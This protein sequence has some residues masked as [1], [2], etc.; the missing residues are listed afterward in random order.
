[1]GFE[2]RALDEG[3]KLD[4]SKKNSEIA[5]K[6]IESYW[7]KEF[8]RIQQIDEAYEK[9]MR[10]ISQLYHRYSLFFLS[11]FYFSS[12]SE[13]SSAGY[14]STMDF[15]RYSRDLKQ[16]YV[17]YYLDKKF[18]TNEEK[19]ENFINGDENVYRSSGKLSPYFGW[20]LAWTYL[21]TLLLFVWGYFRFKKA[22]YSLE[23]ERKKR[24]KRKKRSKPGKPGAVKEVKPPEIPELNLTAGQYR[25]LESMRSNQSFP[26]M[27][28][29]LFSGRI[30]EAVKSRYNGKIRFEGKDITTTPI[31]L[32][33][34]QSFVYLCH[35]ENIPGEIITGNLV[36]L[37]NDFLKANQK[38][39]AKEAKTGTLIEK[40][41][42]SDL[43]DIDN[44]LAKKFGDL[45]DIERFEILVTFAELYNAQIYLFEHILHDMPVKAYLR[46]KQVM[47]NLSEEGS[48][49]INIVGDVLVIPSG[50]PKTSEYTDHKRWS[51]IVDGYRDI[52]TTG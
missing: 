4:L 26:A 30:S 28:Y 51:K 35:P 16:E 49:V 18:Y 20:G 40:L 42:E 50:E 7:R 29:N 23:F 15:Y 9:E 11:T 8:Q 1:M 14:E 3:G 47:E 5:K 43:L 6:I 34:N 48:L 45:E 17:R 33:L 32:P 38:T 39:V 10:K 19:V 22:L 21:V 2:N 13:I 46:L 44:L 52:K 12:T 25:V 37:F 41:R 31:A 27:L 24:R 36:K